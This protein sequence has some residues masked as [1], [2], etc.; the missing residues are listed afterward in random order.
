MLRAYQ[1]QVIRELQDAVAAGYKRILLV[2][3]TG[4]G[5]TVIAGSLIKATGRDYGH[6]LFI[7]HRRELIEQTSRRLRVEGI[8]ASVILAG[9]DGQYD[10]MART[11]VAGIQSLAARLRSQSRD[12]PSG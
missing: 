12:Q 2:A 8:A 9:R 7:A 10:A 6:S 1:D 5:K 3:P 11:Q 4:S